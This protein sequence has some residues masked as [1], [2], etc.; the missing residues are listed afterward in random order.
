MYE[1]KMPGL[2]RATAARLMMFFSPKVFL[3]AAIV[4]IAKVFNVE[5][6]ISKP[7]I[8]KKKWNLVE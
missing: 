8:F 1:E 7:K 3:I 4:I 6:T 5:D 2:K